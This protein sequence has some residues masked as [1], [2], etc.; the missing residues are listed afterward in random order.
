M[1]PETR[2]T[3][4][5]S[6]SGEGVP[7]GKLPGEKTWAGLDTMSQKLRKRQSEGTSF[8]QKH[9]NTGLAGAPRVIQSN[10]RSNRHG[11][12]TCCWDA[13][14]LL[15]AVPPPM[16]KK[17]HGKVGLGGTSTDHLL[18]H[19]STEEGSMYSDCIWQMFAKPSF[20]TPMKEMPKPEK[21]RGT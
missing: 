12:T 13:T 17:S 14:E 19:S 8:Q 1:L 9:S 5:T 16:C 3:W 20:K 18:S 11:R 10:S 7:G 6:T 4:E 2:Y 15:L 21:L